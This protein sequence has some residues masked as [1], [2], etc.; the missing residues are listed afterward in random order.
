MLIQVALSMTVK[1][2]KLIDKNFELHRLFQYRKKALVN[3]ESNEEP[4]S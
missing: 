1:N 2:I 4:A 3:I